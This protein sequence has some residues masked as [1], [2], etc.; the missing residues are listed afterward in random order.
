LIVIALASSHIGYS[1]SMA[2][3]GVW[4]L[5]GVVAFAVAFAIRGKPLGN[6]D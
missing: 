6:Q 2:V 4:V 5:V 1:A 3:I